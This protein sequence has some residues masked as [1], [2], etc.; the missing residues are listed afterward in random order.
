MTEVLL[1]S[2]HN[3][4][5]EL[6]SCWNLIRY[7]PYVVVCL[8]SELQ[9]QRG[10]GITAAQRQQE[11]ACAMGILG[12]EWVQ[13]DHSDAA[14]DW[15]LVRADLVGLDEHLRPQLVFAPAV[16][17]DGHDD[18]SVL[19]AMAADTFGSRLRPYLTYTRLGGKSRGGREVEFD[20]SWIGLKHRALACYRSQ[21][22]TAAAM[23]WPHFA[24]DLREYV[25]AA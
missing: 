7:R 4:D 22:E 11:T 23:C 13:W 20:P 6:F 25:V 3:D 9:E 17:A 24:E 8:R 2:P 19:G 15:D 12:C 14:P 10:T 5:A 21:I 18:H 1:L 16:E